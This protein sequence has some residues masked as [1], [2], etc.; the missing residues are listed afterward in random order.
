MK[1]RLTGS[2]VK[3]LQSLLSGVLAFLS[4]SWI[5]SQVSSLSVQHSYLW[6]LSGVIW[7]GLPHAVLCLLDTSTT[8]VDELDCIDL[9]W[10]GLVDHKPLYTLCC[11]NLF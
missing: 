7:A 4:L 8:V 10:I 5:L 3:I 2:A 11:Y 9:V 1:I 6:C